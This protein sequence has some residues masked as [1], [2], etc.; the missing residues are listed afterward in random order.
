MAKQ[1][2]YHKFI[3]KLN[4]KTIKKAKWNLT[5]PLLTA[6]RNKNDIVALNDSQ[7]IRWICELNGIGNPDEKV[8]S[9]KRAIKME[10]RKPKSRETKNNI[11]KLYD[12]LY[13]LQY[14]KDCLYVIMNSDKDYDRANKGFSINGYEYSRL[15]GTN[16][17]VKKSTITY[18]GNNL[19]DEINKRIDNGRNK[20]VPVVP[21]KLEAYKSLTCSGSIPVSKPRIIVVPDCRVKFYEDVIMINDEN[22]GEPEMKIEKNYEI[23]YCDSDGYGFMSPEYSKKINEE[24]HGTEY[25]GKTISGVN[26]RYAWT[27]GMIFTF[28][29]VK[30][31][32]LKNNGNYMVTDAWGDL[33]DVREADVILTTS[34]LKLWDSYDSF[35]DYDRNCEENHYQF[36]VSKTTPHRLENVRNANYQ[37][38]QDFEFTDEELEHLVLPTINE[39]SDVLGGDLRKTLV[40]LKGMF[41]TDETVDYIDNDWIKALMID[42]RLIKDPFI[43]TKIHGMIKK[44]IQM[45]AKGSIKLNGNFAIVSGDLYSLAQSMFGLPV[46]GLLKKGEVYHKYWI[47]KGANEISCFRAPMTCHNNIRKMKVTHS[48]EMDFWYQYNETGIILNSWDTTCDALNGADKDSDTFFTT[49]NEI[50][51]RNTLNDM[52]IECLQR[53]APKIIPSEEDLVQAN[54][55]SF[56]DEI[57]I[58]TNHVTAMIERR[59][60]FPKDSKE[61]QTLSY[62][63][64]CGQLYQQN[65]I[66]KAKGIIAKSMP[67]YWYDK[68]L[69]R[70]METDSE[71]ELA[72]K[73]FNARIAADK[74]PYFMKYVYPDLMAEYNKYIKDTDKKCIREFKMHMAELIQKENK[75]VDEQNF[76]DYYEKLMPVGNNP[77]VVNRICRIFEE[78]FKDFLKLRCKSSDFDYQILKSGLDY[79]KN[80]YNKI[81]KIYE[82]YTE[83]TRIF[84]QF[85][86]AERTEKDEAALNRLIM[87]NQFKSECEKIC[88]NAKE[89]CDI[90]LDLT[91][92]TSKS[93]QF[94]WDICSDTI[95]D[96]LLKKNGNIIHYPRHVDNR[97]PKDISSPLSEQDSVQASHIQGNIGEFEFAGE[98]FI[99]CEKHYKEE[100]DLF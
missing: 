73:E 70:P 48:E 36:S 78:H 61:Y 40:F 20:S 32:E 29:Y 56:G 80:D 1:R 52:T 22:D 15:L 93:K 58:T 53:K 17:G 87:L 45:A 27:K 41:T 54:K 71:D 77:C 62:R 63:I 24:L 8:K 59:A 10:K 66:D 34:M 16:G 9:I 5:L 85:I 30:F 75:T 64:M 23:N 76:V 82:N 28:D 46:T 14:Q 72:A 60:G 19:I 33:R 92:K 74:K 6:M 51:V 79:N 88:P 69:L 38:L 68:T 98:Q 65:A 7:L 67:K 13:N 49:D 21:A 44:R 84:N 50:I 18:I 31:A 95:I 94:A 90:I 4:S 37:F 35:E 83:E 89:L 96:N 42:E 39:I 99:M 3:Y 25:C 43:L 86:K 2:T 26:T 11:K 12:E 57:G 81:A 55:L 100:D 91:Y 97:E 47:E